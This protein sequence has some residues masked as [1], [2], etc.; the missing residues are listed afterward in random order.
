MS[1]VLANFEKAY[2]KLE[3][4]YL[5]DKEEEAK[6]EYIEASLKLVDSANGGKTPLTPEQKEL[7]SHYLYISMP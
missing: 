1:E 7:L 4:C 6:Q 2:K 3:E 5:T